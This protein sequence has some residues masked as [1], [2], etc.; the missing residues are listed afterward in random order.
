MNTFKLLALTYLV[1]LV[2]APSLYSADLLSYILLPYI[3]VVYSVSV[4]VLG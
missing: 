1:T 2:C 4:F 3:P